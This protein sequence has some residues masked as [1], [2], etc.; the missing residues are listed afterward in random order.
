[1]IH[2]ERSRVREPRILRSRAALAAR[3]AASTSP[4][5][6]AKHEAFKVDPVLYGNGIRRALGRLFNNKCAFCE[7]TIGATLPA[8]IAHYRPAEGALGSDGTYSPLHYRWLA[9]EWSNLYLSCPECI[10]F[11]GHRFPVESER[12]KFG[13]SGHALDGE[14]PLLLDPCGTEL[15]SN[16]LLFNVDGTVASAT[17]AGRTTIDIFGL[18]RRSLVNMR[19]D[20]STMSRETLSTIAI[21]LSERS[22]PLKSLRQMIAL[23]VSPQQSFSALNQQLVAEWTRELP[24]ELRAVLQDTDLP[25]SIDSISEIAKPKL[26]QLVEDFARYEARSEQF[27]LL[28]SRSDS[29]Y[30]KARF[31]ERVEIE[32][33]RLIPHLQLDFA[34]PDSERAHWMAILGENGSGKSS[35]LQA[36]ALTLMGSLY[37][38]SLKLDP[39]ALIRKSLTRKAVQ[40]RRATIRIFLSG[41]PQPIE[42]SISSR[43]FRASDDQP[44]CLLLGYG[45]TRLLPRRGFAPERGSKFSRVGNLF[46]PFVPL[47][48]A[49][50][51]FLKRK[52]NEFR[53]AANVVRS[54]LSLPDDSKV[55]VRREK[56]F[57]EGRPLNQLSDGYQSMLALAADIMEVMF[58]KWSDMKLAEGVVLIDEIESHL[59]PSWKMRI[60]KQFR[61]CFPRIQFVITTHDPLCLR[62][63]EKG[64]VVSMK[65]DGRGGLMLE[66]DLPDIKGLE[67]DQ[68]LT[69]DYFGLNTTIDPEVEE[70]FRKYYTLLAKPKPNHEELRE[71]E[72][73]RVSIDSRRLLGSN[74]R[75]RLMLEAIDQYLADARSRPADKPLRDDIKQRIAA[76][77]IQPSARGRS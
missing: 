19:L 10:R 16:H 6:G 4:P 69:S 31:I 45:A 44:K 15:P 70:I 64:E 72:Q 33:F 57:I 40:P 76:M 20:K 65:R 30:S 51:W 35:V 8:D 37:R 42:L 47:A 26:A 56:L 13:A 18:N 29:Y 66:R 25:V 55:S 74:E 12:A 62:G 36:I 71:R 41:S 63:L 2:V 54:L 28:G 11:K 34:G 50:E 23:L 5:S 61:T 24:A 46:N 38:Q 77:W 27:S 43:T 75:E 9:Y 17:I 32:D 73:L 21:K 7:S 59:H 39:R 60:I 49:N 14:L 1:M 48:R 52:P 67:V 58:A 53:A 3:N 22:A 68:L